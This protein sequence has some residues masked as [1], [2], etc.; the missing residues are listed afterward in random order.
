MRFRTPPVAREKFALLIGIN[1]RTHRYRRN[2]LMAPHKDVDS[3]KQLLIGMSDSG[4][5]FYFTLTPSAI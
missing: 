3:V 4:T 5:S 1:Y 2:R